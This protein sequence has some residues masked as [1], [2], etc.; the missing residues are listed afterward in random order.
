MLLAQL[1]NAIVAHEWPIIKSLETLPQVG[2]GVLCELEKLRPHAAHPIKNFLHVGVGG[3]A[4]LFLGFQ[5]CD[6]MGLIE[7]DRDARSSQGGFP[8]ESMEGHS[9]PWSGLTEQ[10]AVNYHTFM[11]DF[12]RG[13]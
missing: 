3:E 13:R 4:I 2:V 11:I 6:P 1:L 9:L 7:D 10:D 5:R 12:C 8:E